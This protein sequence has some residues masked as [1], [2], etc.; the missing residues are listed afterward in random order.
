MW[1]YRDGAFDDDQ[2]ED[3]KKRMRTQIYFLLLYADEQN[4]EL[5]QNVDVCQAIDSALTWFSGL[6]SVLGYPPALVKVIS[7]LE[8][9]KS[10][11]QSDAYDFKKYR[12]L[13]LDAGNEV[14]RIGGA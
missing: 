12:K 9:A 3:V 10:E 6:N 7:L 4:K 5:Y 13:V 8:A 11:Y 2:I 14:L 1:Q